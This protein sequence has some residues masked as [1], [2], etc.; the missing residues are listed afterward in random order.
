MSFCESASAVSF[1][2][3]RSPVG[4]SR[5]GAST[6]ACLGSS[7]SASGYAA[8]A[9]SAP[10]AGY[11]RCARTAG[12]GS[13]RSTAGSC[14]RLSQQLSIV[15]KIK[16]SASIRNSE[17]LTAGI[18]VDTGHSGGGNSRSAD[19][20]CSAPDDIYIAAAVARRYR[21]GSGTESHASTWRSANR[22]SHAIRGC[23]GNIITINS[24]LRTGRQRTGIE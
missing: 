21:T 9:P 11:N 2:T 24:I 12:P 8:G 14:R 16:C 17:S 19:R 5:I 18:A 6:G 10:A 1:Q 20:I 13:T 3:L 23:S 4:G 22:N 7:A 15:I